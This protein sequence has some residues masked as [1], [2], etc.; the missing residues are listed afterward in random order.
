[1]REASSLMDW[2]EVLTFERTQTNFSG[3]NEISIA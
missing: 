3:G 2:R 1:M